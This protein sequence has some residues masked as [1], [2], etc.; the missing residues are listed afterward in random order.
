MQ[1]LELCRYDPLDLFVP[2]PKI[3]KRN[4][5]NNKMNNTYIYKILFSVCQFD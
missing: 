2:T 3:S 4:N 5:N 1:V